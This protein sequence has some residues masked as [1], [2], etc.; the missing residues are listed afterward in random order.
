MTADQLYKLRR[1]DRAAASR[2]QPAVK[3]ENWR[4]RLR[5]RVIGRGIAMM[6]GPSS[7]LSTNVAADIPLL[8]A[9]ARLAYLKALGAVGV[10]SFVARSGLGHDFIC[11]VGDLA[12]FPFYHPAA[13]RAELELAAGWLHQDEQAIAFDVGANGGFFS[14]QLAQM[15]ALVKIYAFEPVPTTFGN[16]AQSVRRLGLAD[17]VEPVA[18]AVLDGPGAVQMSWSDKNSLLAQVT[19]HGL[20]ARAGDRLTRAEGITLD[21]FCASAG[22][23]PSLVKIDVEGSEAAVLRGAARLLARSDR[24]AILFEFNPVTLA[25]CDADADTLA[26][27]LAGYTLHYV[28]DLRGRMLPFGAPV[29]DLQKIDW[30]CNLFAVPRVEAAARRWAS[31]SREVQDRMA[32]VA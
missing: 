9:G 4:Q 16:L 7:S 28:D 24:P 15:R 6:C 32:P 12:G 29:G 25:E 20:N 23:C 8:R 18:A 21:G 30:V 1:E 31:V 26:A 10:T 13:Y 17:R 19:P 14:T 11:H 22:V 27:L 2:A 5:T 3:Q